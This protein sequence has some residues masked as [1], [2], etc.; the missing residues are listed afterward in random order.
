MNLK[1]SIIF[2]TDL[3]IISSTNEKILKNK[4]DCKVVRT[5]FSPVSL[6]I[7]EDTPALLALD[8]EYIRLVIVPEYDKDEISG[9]VG[10]CLSQTTAVSLSAFKENT[11]ESN[12]VIDT[13]REDLT[14]SIFTI[15]MFKYLSDKD[16]KPMVEENIE[17]LKQIAL[18]SLYDA[19][20]RFLSQSVFLHQADASSQDIEG[21]LKNIMEKINP[22][23]E[24]INVSVDLEETSSCFIYETKDFLTAACMNMI[25]NAVFVAK[26]CGKTKVT[27]RQQFEYDKEIC[28]IQVDV[29]AGT[30]DYKLLYDNDSKIFIEQLAKKND[31][32][33]IQICKNDYIQNLSLKGFICTN[34]LHQPKPTPYGSEFDIEYQYLTPVIDDF[35]PQPEYSDNEFW[36]FC[37]FSFKIEYFIQYNKKQFNYIMIDCLFFYR[38]TLDFS[39]KM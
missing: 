38:K 24:K 32:S 16:S 3:E 31:G 12:E 35:F 11:A 14:N 23:L 1:N 10:I 21:I 13:I 36:F 19:T 28:D 22:Y 2:N 7:S 26:Q 29:N 4:D 34:E 30:T 9:Y 25:V 37:F 27:V 20:R 5:D 15:E 18:R 39:E 17:S 33:F 6:P 8:N